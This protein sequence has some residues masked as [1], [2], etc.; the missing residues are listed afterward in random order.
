[1][2][3]IR[4][5]PLNAKF[6]IRGPPVFT[7]GRSI[8]ST[9]ADITFEENAA[10]WEVMLSWRE[11]QAKQNVVVGCYW[12][13][14]V[15]SWYGSWILLWSRCLKSLGHSLG[16]SWWQVTGVMVV[17]H[18]TLLLY[19]SRSKQRLLS[20]QVQGSW[21]LLQLLCWKDACTVAWF[22]RRN[23]LRDTD[24]SQRTLYVNIGR[25]AAAGEVLKCVEQQ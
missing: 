23:W 10:G 18:A 2:E 21:M 8:H 14:Q 19:L 4:G 12:R 6:V 7:S 5:N 25:R 17:V 16:I 20:L 11:Y 24:F 13:H 22:I 1:M 15:L 3:V 9:T